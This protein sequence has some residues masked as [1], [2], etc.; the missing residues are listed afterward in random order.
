MLAPGAHAVLVGSDL[1]GLEARAHGL[2]VRDSFLVVCPSG[3]LTAW[4][5]RTPLEAPTVA[6][7]WLATGTGALALG[8]CRIPIAGTPRSRWA[9]NVLLVHC[10]GCERDHD[11]WTCVPGCPAH[12]LD[13]QSG[14]RPGSGLRAGQAIAGLGYSGG[15]SGMTART[16]YGG[17]TGGA[18]RFFGQFANLGECMAWLGRLTRA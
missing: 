13:A 8:E 16:D 9:T 3:V 7:Q 1:A 6:S 14:E 15:A 10:P 12:A 17:D 4:L 11:V 2:L 5:V 18:S